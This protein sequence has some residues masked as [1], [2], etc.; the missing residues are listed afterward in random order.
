VGVA[1]PYFSLAADNSFGPIPRLTHAS[2]PRDDAAPHSESVIVAAIRAG[3]PA[4]FRTL[5]TDF[6]NEL[7]S[8]AL[9]FTRSRDLAEEAVQLAVTRLWLARERFAP[10]SSVRAYLFT[11]VRHNALELLR[12]D[13]NIAAAEAGAAAEQRDT[14]PAPDTDLEVLPGGQS[15]P[16]ITPQPVP[17]G[18]PEHRR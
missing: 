2:S 17:P 4:T 18:G 15:V 5:Y 14:L 10:T 8:F 6:Y 12:R 16:A 1:L 9:T 13:R 3:D 7:A 11:A